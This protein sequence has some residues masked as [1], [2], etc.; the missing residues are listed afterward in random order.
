MYIIMNARVYP[1]RR[2]IATNNLRLSKIL[3]WN[4]LN[5]LSLFWKPN[6][7]DR[8]ANKLLRF[9]TTFLTAILQSWCL[10]WRMH[11]LHFC[12]QN[13]HF[14]ASSVTKV[15]RFLWSFLS[16]YGSFH[17]LQENQLKHVIESSVFFWLER[18]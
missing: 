14:L 6:E 7:T 16:D 4:A 17:F 18:W 11:G 15:Q 2:P 1:N 5:L 10:L 13:F 8:E 9:C 12:L 3:T